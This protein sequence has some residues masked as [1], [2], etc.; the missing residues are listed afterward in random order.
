M[1]MLVLE[2]HKLIKLF[3]PDRADVPILIRRTKRVVGPSLNL[4]GQSL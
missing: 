3:A 1:T 4:T 2:D